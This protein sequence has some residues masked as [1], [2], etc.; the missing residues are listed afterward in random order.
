MLFSI[1]HAIALNY[2]FHQYCENNPMQYKLKISRKMR[3]RTLICRL[4]FLKTKKS[5]LYR[6]FSSHHTDNRNLIHLELCHIYISATVKGWL[7]GLWDKVRMAWVAICP[8]LPGRVLAYACWP[9]LIMNGA[10]L[11]SVLVWSINYMI[12]L[13]M[14]KIWS[15]FPTDLLIF[16][17]TFSR[18]L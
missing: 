3:L 4:I 17:L 13:L 7:R 15:L 9:G 16:P 5:S 10:L 8:S 6:Q 2:E 12:T 11:K 1:P 18:N 14:E